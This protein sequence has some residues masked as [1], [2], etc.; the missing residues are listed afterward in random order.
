ML[1]RDEE[2]ARVPQPHPI[3]ASARSGMDNG[4]FTVTRRNRCPALLASHLVGHTR[5]WT[6][7]EVVKAEPPG[8]FFH[9][10]VPFPAPIAVRVTTA[11]HRLLV[12]YSVEARPIRSNGLSISALS[13]I[14]L[15]AIA[16]W[17]KVCRG[18]Y[19]GNRPLPPPFTPIRRSMVSTTP[20]AFWTTP[21]SIISV[22]VTNGQV[23]A[24]SLALSTAGS[25]VR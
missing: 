2:D 24:S 18:T 13:H 20:A 14:T 19:F 21:K 15:H 6:L 3:G 7:P 16:I 25:S 5:P 23:V 22:V 8:Q 17:Q 12:N 4:P 1:R 10:I 11:R 9:D